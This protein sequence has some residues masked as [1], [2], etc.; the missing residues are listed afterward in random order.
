M[1]SANNRALVK[2]LLTAAC[3]ATRRKRRAPEAERWPTMRASLTIS[4]LL[5][6]LAGC[7]KSSAP[8]ITTS[9]DP[10]GAAGSLADPRAIDSEDVLRIDTTA[11]VEVVRASGRAP[12]RYLVDKFETHD[13]VLLLLGEEHGIRENCE[14]VASVLEPLYREAGERRFATEFVRSR[15]SERVNRLAM[16]HGDRVKFNPGHGRYMASRSD[17]KYWGSVIL[18]VEDGT[19]PEQVK[20][21]PGSIR[22]GRR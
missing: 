2:R 8:V 15:N 14:F 4:V 3:R 21:L 7:S 17:T 11:Y 19:T 1:W 10:K 12:I 5:V 22:V 16:K 13:L 6:A 18:F 9:T 20:Q